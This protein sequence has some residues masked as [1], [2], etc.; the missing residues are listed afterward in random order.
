MN[1]SEGGEYS[2][3][4]LQ[5]GGHEEWDVKGERHEGVSRH[6]HSCAVLYQDCHS[7]EWAQTDTRRLESMAYAEAIRLWLALCAI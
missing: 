2:E 4:A 3:C 6:A 7:G 5:A 1:G